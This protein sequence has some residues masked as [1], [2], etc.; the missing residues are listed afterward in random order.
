MIL[1]NKSSESRDVIQYGPGLCAGE[2][3][4]YQFSFRTTFDVLASAA[5]STMR[6]LHSAAAGSANS[7]KRARARFRYQPEIN[8]APRFLP[9]AY[10]SHDPVRR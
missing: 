2:G 8:F 5:L 1:R 4:L 7:I 10:I 9:E 3:R 6:F